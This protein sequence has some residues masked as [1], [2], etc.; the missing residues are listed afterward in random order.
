M[1]YPAYEKYKDSGVEWLGEIPEHW[2]MIRFRFLLRD[3][4]D[5]L[6]IGPFGS[7]IKLD[8]LSNEG[9]KI[10][11]QE[12]VIKRDFTIGHRYVDEDKFMELSVYEL[13]PNAINLRNVAK[14]IKYFKFS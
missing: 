3:G 1:K 2:Q 10:Y 8:D 5:G 4:Y 14:P 9:Y 12:N 11:G 6:K 13:Q 7:Q